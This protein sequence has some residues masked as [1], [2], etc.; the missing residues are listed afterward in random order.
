MTSVVTLPHIGS[1]LSKHPL[2]D[3]TDL[4]SLS[5]LDMCGAPIGREFQ[6]Q[7][8]SRMPKH[9]HVGQG[10]LLQNIYTAMFIQN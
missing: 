1:L 9:T 2:V 6:K 8:A 4:S 7:V 5:S 3:Q 10:E